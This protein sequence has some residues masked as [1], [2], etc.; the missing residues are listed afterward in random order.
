MGAPSYEGKQV[1]MMDRT[2]DRFFVSSLTV[3]VCRVLGTL[4]CE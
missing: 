3:V 1:Y 2:I 4:T